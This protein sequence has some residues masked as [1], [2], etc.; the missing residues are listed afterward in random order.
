MFETENFFIILLSS[1]SGGTARQTQH[2]LQKLPSISE[3][4][5]IQKKKKKASTRLF[6][7][8]PMT[9]NFGLLI[10]N[11]GKK[12]RKQLVKGAKNWLD[13]RPNR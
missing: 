9:L 13:G 2:S 6:K 4:G 1:Q 10:Q 11:S 7:N 3:E 5:E 12:F 8:K